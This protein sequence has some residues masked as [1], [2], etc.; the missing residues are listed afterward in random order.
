MLRGVGIWME[1]DLTVRE[2]QV[3]GWLSDLVVEEKGKGLEAKLGYLKVFVDGN[4][5]K[6]LE[7]EG[8]LVMLKF[9]GKGKGE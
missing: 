3:Q 7:R 1:D 6:W 5:Y 8:R 9:Q 2:R 4:W